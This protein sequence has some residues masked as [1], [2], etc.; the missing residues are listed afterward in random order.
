MHSEGLA[1][2]TETFVRYGVSR[3]LE[4]GIGYLWKPGNVRPLAS[5]TF[6]TETD[7]RPAFTAGLMHDA[8]GGGRQGVFV[9]ASKA[10]PRTM[11]GMPVSVY[12]GGAQISGESGPRFIGGLNV[13]FN[14]W[15]S[16][17]VQFDGKY[18]HP[19]LTARVGRVK[20]APVRLGIV[21][22]Q[23]DKLGPLIAIDVPLGRRH[24]QR[25][26]L[27]TRPTPASSLFIRSYAVRPACP[28]PPD[29]R[30]CRSANAS[31]YCSQT[32]LPGQG[33]HPSR[34]RSRWHT[35][36]P[37]SWSSTNSV[38]KRRRSSGSHTETRQLSASSHRIP[39][40]SSIPEPGIRSLR[41]VPDRS[42]YVNDSGHEY[43]WIT[44]FR[45]GKYLA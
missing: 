19:A 8:L 23:G 10:L 11:L 7:D 35:W 45:P 13:P 38:T 32:W 29:F 24:C 14:D 28:T 2:E 30:R 6:V 21:A 40:S 3:R 36:C 25:R 43:T 27:G 18:V 1:G 5:S 37:T 22:A 15:L 44:G 17:S 31:A 4:V 20:G 12:G 9:T 41:R 16:A 26:G 39:Y 42:L 33:D 34:L